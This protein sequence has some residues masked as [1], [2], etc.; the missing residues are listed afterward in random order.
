MSCTAITQKNTNGVHSVWV[1]IRDAVRR[2][3]RHRILDKSG[4]TKH[5][6]TVSL[7]LCVSPQPPALCGLSQADMLPVYITSKGAPA[8][9][10]TG[11]IKNRHPRYAT[12]S[13]LWSLWYLHLSFKR[14]CILEPLNACFLGTLLMQVASSIV[15]TLLPRLRT[16]CRERMLSACSAPVT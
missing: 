5:T 4:D 16:L 7:P 13:V 2:A 3:G 9:R 6:E 12:H 1:S 10:I 14:K 15:S 11:G 8:P